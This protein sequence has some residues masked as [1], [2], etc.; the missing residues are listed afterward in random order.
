MLVIGLCGASGSGKG[1]VSAI[2]KKRNIPCL[3]TDELYHR[4]IEGPSD[5]TSDLTKS[6]GTAI[7]GENG[8]INR[9]VL[10]DVVFSDQTGQK[11]KKL[12]EITHYHIHKET[13][14]WIEKYRTKEFAAVCIDAPM[15]FESHFDRDC[16]VTVAVLADEE[17]KI[18]R[19][20]QRDHISEEKAKMRLA[21]QISD[22]ELLKKC[23]YAL[24]NTQTVQ[25]LETQIEQ[26]IEKLLH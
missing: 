6:F 11:H 25:A 17:T 13:V 16:D 15:L 10:A 21:H 12:N 7:L 18:K 4:L 14:R 9:K 5:C 26:L 20:E 1:T 2:L 23:D 3:D 24:Q 8:G 19:I 22:A